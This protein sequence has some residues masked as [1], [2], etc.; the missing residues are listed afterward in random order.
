MI[1]RFDLEGNGETI[2]DIDDSRILPRPLKHCR[3]PRRQ[4][5]QMHA[6]TLVTAVLAPHDAE[7]ADLRQ[8]RLASENLDDPLIFAV[9]Q[10]VLSE[11]IVCNHYVRTNAVTMDSKISFPSALPRMSSLDRSGCG[12]IASTCP[13]SFTIPAMLCRDPFGLASGVICPF[14]S[15]YRKTI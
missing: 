6:R 5:P 4:A 8:V 2:A 15:A 3:P 9:G 7:D 1:V 10:S 14:R 12:I 13:C 11:Q